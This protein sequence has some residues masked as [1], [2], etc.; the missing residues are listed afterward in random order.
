MKI[1]SAFC[2]ISASWDVRCSASIPYIEVD[3][4]G[5]ER[6]DDKNKQDPEKPLLELIDVCG[7]TNSCNNSSTQALRGNNTE[8]SYQ[9]A[10][11]EINKHAFVAI[12]GTS[13]ESSKNASDD[14][15]AGVDQE[16]WSDY[17]VLHLLDIGGGGLLGGIQGNDD[18]ANDTLKAAD[19]SYE[20]QTLFEKDGRQYRS[21]DNTQGTKWSDQDSINEGICN[22]IADFTVDRLANEPDS[23]NGPCLTLESSISFQSTTTHF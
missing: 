15:H 8:S 1:L 4:L 2:G 6:T 14:Y 5:Q 19:L 20:A 7:M 10:D 23:F 9:T 16:S 13:P 22:K 3:D 21:D 11:G 17:I 12:T 18:G